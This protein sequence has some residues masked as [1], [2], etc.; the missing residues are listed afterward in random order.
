MSSDRPAL[1]LWKIPLDG[2]LMIDYEKVSPSERAF[3]APLFLCM[4]T[5]IKGMG[6]LGFSISKVK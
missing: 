3:L 5:Y 2:I 4:L 1:W 6:G